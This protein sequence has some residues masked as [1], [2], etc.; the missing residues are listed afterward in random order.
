MKRSSIWSTTL[1]GT[2]NWTLLKADQKYVESFKTWC[3]RFMEQII[4]TDCVRSSQGKK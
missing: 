1:Y 4:Q 3:W 2:E